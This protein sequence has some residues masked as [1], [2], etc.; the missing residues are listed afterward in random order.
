M[1]A[2]LLLIIG[3]ITLGIFGFTDINIIKKILPYR[4]A[5]KLLYIFIGIAT[6]ILMFNRNF[7]LPYNT[8]T[9]TNYLLGI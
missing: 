6:V 8:T 3:G 2:K 5:Q 9:F 7:Y 4:N 1:F